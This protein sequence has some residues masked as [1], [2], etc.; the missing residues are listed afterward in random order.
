[1][2]F[3]IYSTI[4]GATARSVELEVVA[5]NIAN[6][7]TVGFKEV[8]PSFN[9]ELQSVDG[10]S[11]GEAAQPL[12][13]HSGNHIN[14]APGQLYPTGSEF[15]VAI[16]GDGFFEIQTKDGPRYT[17]S[18]NFVLNKER[19]LSTPSGYPVMGQDGLITVPD[20][21]RVNIGAAGDVSVGETS[22][23]KI[24]ISAFADTKKFLLE[25][26]NLMNAGA[27]EQV[28]SKGYRLSQGYLEGSNVNLVSNMARMIEVSRA[29]EAHQKSISKQMKS[30][31]LLQ[32]IA[33]IS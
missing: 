16:Q 11:E 32:Q 25:G 26:H 19:V 8:R 4:S 23:G 18:G 13:T 31:E 28:T 14:M 3:G 22:V 6:V 5:N 17:R 10:S 21:G 15:D 2:G 33:K 1:M 29:Y 27:S 7:N 20:T 12:V 30:A 24:K 9:S